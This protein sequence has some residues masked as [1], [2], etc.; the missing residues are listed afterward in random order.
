MLTRLTFASLLVLVLSLSAFAQKQT[1]L[2][3]SYLYRFEW[4]GTELT[5]NSNGTFKS[6]FSD[7]TGITTDYGTYVVSSDSVRL[8]TLKLTR[9]GYD[10]KKEHDLTKGKERKKHLDTNK[11]FKPETR[12]L[13]IIRWDARIYLMH[14]D[15]FESFIDALNLGFEPR[16]VDGYRAY[17]GAIFLR[18][19][20]E[21]KGVI[22]PPPLPSEYLTYLLS[23]PVIATVGE[24]EKI[25][26][27]FI[28]TID[29]GSE[30]GLRKEMTLVT[31]DDNDSFYKSQWIISVEPHTARVQIWG[32][33]KVGDKLTTRIADVKRFS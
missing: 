8:T 13:Q 31:V 32:D 5:L 4:G 15:L 12:E 17:Y 22:G 26:D 21:G 33:I 27:R 7:C 30:D 2:V 16:E 28:A 1:D 10:E 20:D 18:E 11:P 29:R 24:V 25:D 9:R 3:G 23:A 6:A 19:G 14:R